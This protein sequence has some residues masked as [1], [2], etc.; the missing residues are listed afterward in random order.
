MWLTA[1]RAVSGFF[2]LAIHFASADRLPVLV[3]GNGLRRDASGSPSRCR[4]AEHAAFEALRHV[5]ARLTR[6][7]TESEALAALVAPPP[8]AS[9]AEPVLSALQVAAGFETAIGAMF[10][11][12]LAAPVGDDEASTAAAQLLS[13]SLPKA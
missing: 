1:T 6:L 9:P 7:K 8:D 11:D 5:E 3:F 4:A 2:A 12:D 13:M 10:E